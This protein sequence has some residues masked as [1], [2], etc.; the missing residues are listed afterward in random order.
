M[1]KELLKKYVIDY[2]Q[3]LINDLKESL[4]D[5]GGSGNL[6]DTEAK[7]PEDYSHIDESRDFKKILQNK[8]GEAEYELSRLEKLSTEPMDKPTSGAL[9]VTDKLSFYISLATL[10]FIIDGK[11]FI[12]IS[13]NAPMF[14]VISR[15]K[16]GDKFKVGSVEYKILSIS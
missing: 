6:D 12:G 5:L 15:K 4:K 2:K 14:G 16:V 8:L 1:D 7:D 3:N 13:E 11:N 9:I 10:P